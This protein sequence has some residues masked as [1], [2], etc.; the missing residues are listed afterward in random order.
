MPK[1]S[2]SNMLLKN[3]IPPFQLSLTVGS[4][5]ATEIAFK[6][7]KPLRSEGNHLEDRVE[8]IQEMIDHKAYSQAIE[9]STE[10][11]TITLAGFRYLQ[12]YHTVFEE[13]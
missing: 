13:I 12:T 5:M 1:K 8:R 10:L 2:L 11:M 9:A 4:K 7:F 6:P 3:V